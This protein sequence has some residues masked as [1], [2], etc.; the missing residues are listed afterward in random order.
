MA[1]CPA[2]FSTV[3]NRGRDGF[4]SHKACCTPPGVV[5]A[6]ALCSFEILLFFIALLPSS[7]RGL[8]SSK[9][10][11]FRLVQLGGRGFKRLT[12]AQCDYVFRKF[13]FETGSDVESSYCP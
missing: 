9:A 6:V 2:L 11:P 13:S 8:P 12:L 4:T 5:S 3:P 10:F 1:I 7:I